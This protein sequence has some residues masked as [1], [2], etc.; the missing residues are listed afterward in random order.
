[1]TQILWDHGAHPWGLTTFRQLASEGITGV[2][3]NMNWLAV[4][5]E[6]GRFNFRT[7]NTYLHDCQETGLQLVPI[8]WEY[9]YSGNPPPWLPG[10]PEIL[11]DGQRGQEPAFWSK[12][13][14]HDYMTY[15][16]KTIKDMS[17]SP[18]YGG[19][20]I[21]YGWL[22]AGYGPNGWAGYAP[23]DILEFHRWLARQYGTIDTFDKATRTTYKT[24]ADVPA[25]SPGQPLFFVHEQFRLWSYQTLLG[26]LLADVRQ[27]TKK[28]LYIYY[29]GGIANDSQLGNVP[30]NVFA[31]AK[32]Y[33]AAV[34][35]DTDSHTS[36]A[37]L[38]GFLSQAYHVPLLTE[39]TPVP[40]S[41]EQLAQWL[42]QYPLEGRFRDGADYYLYGGPG[43]QPS[44]EPATYPLYV[45]WHKALS[46]VQGSLP[47]YDIGIMLGYDQEYY[48]NN[49]TGLPGDLST[50]GYYL[51]VLRPAAN[52]FS[53]LSVLDGAVNLS[54]FKVIVDWNSDLK[55]SMLNPRLARMLHAFVARGGKVI[56]GPSLANPNPSAPMSV[57][58]EEF[59]RLPA[60]FVLSPASAE[61]DTFASVASDKAFIVLSNTGNLAYHGRLAIPHAMLL[62]LLPHDTT[63]H[64][65]STT[66]TGNVVQVHSH[67][68]PEWDISL[69]ASS[70]AVLE[71][72]P[73]P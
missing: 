27:V 35:M 39:W 21:D 2:E 40:G 24:F 20:Y 46:E 34:N 4:E 28:P 11:S 44:Y 19:S 57:A 55:A 10:G 38:F 56:P 30:D 65:Y 32:Q 14:F 45:R 3:I 47:Q 25:F 54:H 66:L 15:I 61:I 58:Q 63:H 8:F 71:M 69:P 51:R 68:A 5:P 16:Q 29:G 26:R 36:F 12:R 23:Q 49:A 72:E 22:D 53:D 33:H 67:G 64:V 59:P 18:A 41:P 6:P 31:V 17:Q 43:D 13:A 62:N 52:V 48:L 1:M 37:A 73:S 60:E 42:G 70:I 7:L 50:L 9:G